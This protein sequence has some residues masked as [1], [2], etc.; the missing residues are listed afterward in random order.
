MA[1]NSVDVGE[2][3]ADAVNGDKIADDSINSEHIVDGS[4]DNV[5]L[6]NSAITVGDGSSTTAMA[7]GSTITFAGTT[8]EVE[9][10]ESG[11]TITVGLGSL[12]VTGNASITG[13]LTV[14]GTRT[15]VNVTNMAVEDSLVSY[16]T[17][18]SSDAV[19]IGFFG[20]YNDGSNDLATGLF[21]DAN[22]GKWKLF[23][24]SQETISGNVVDKSATGY[25]VA[26]FVANTEGTHTGAVVGNVTGDVTGSAGTVTSIAS[27]VIDSDAMT[28]ATAT[29][30]ASAEST[31]AYV[32]ATV[33]AISTTLTIGADSGSDD[34][35]V[36]GTD[37]INFNGTAN[38]IETTVS[39]NAI[40]VG[41]VNAPTVSG[42]MTAGFIGTLTGN[43]TGN[44]S[45]NASR[46]CYYTCN[47]KSNWWSII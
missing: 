43:V 27:H 22:D 16:A 24:D 7:L 40:T 1:G 17:G 28:G 29:N 41:L 46:R 33:G 10:A 30:V 9:V 12:S 44:V 20:K 19:D 25:T 18:N 47:S 32:D 14:S 45:G 31:K 35:V 11:G 38:E 39:D 42:T 15:D 3:V 5:H 37:T 23:K 34:G 6:A 26:S 21:R 13:N 36:V 4:V 2:I 8:N